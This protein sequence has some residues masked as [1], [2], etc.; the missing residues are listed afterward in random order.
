M[1]PRRPSVRV[2]LLAVVALA[3]WGITLQPADPVTAEGRSGVGTGLVSA[4]P[5]GAEPANLR[6]KLDRPL[7]RFSEPRPIKHRWPPLL[8]LVPAAALL[9]ATRGRF[10][11]R[12]YP[13]NAVLPRPGLLSAPRGPPSLQ[14][15]A[16]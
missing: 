6:S 13:A 8:A 4:T 11:G 7:D 10:T 1:M 2:G 14:L 16:L 12:P 5:P 9:A 15:S 3:L